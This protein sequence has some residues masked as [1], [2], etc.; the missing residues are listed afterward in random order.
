MITA[1]T[2]A[3]G[4]VGANLIRA[5]LEQGRTVRVLV[6]TDR[7]AIEGLNVETVEGNID[8]P[9]SLCRAFDGV[10]VAYHLATYISLLMSE[11]PQC[12]MVNVNGTRNVVEACLHTGV[13]RLVHFSSIHALEQEP[14]DIP[15]DE[16]R[17]LVTSR[18]CPPYDRSKAAG[19][20]EVREGIERGLD[21]VI[22][23]PTGIIGPYDYKPSYFGEVLLSFARGNMPALIDAGFNWVDVRD[24]VK[25]A[26]QAEKRASTGVKYLL[27][28]HWASMRDLA[29]MV[30]GAINVSCPGFACPLWVADIGAPFATAFAR[31]AGKRPLYT[32]VA[33]MALRG[34]RSISHERATRELDY[35]PRPLSQTIADTLRWFEENGQLTGGYKHRSQGYNERK[36]I[37]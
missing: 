30:A 22:I 26:M 5:L 9:E 11:W 23:N 25:G 19:E 8:D 1:V 33:L 2:G 27:S 4:H 12:E 20:R 24:V 35:H 14:K 3:T 18:R 15:V 7:R 6:R 37:L 13:R 21:A 17:P 28:G 16:M 32:R 31:L 36:N 10:E 29:A 34:N